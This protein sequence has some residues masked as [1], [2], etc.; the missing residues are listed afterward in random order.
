MISIPLSETDKHAETAQ[1]RPSYSEVGEEEKMIVKV[2]LNCFRVSHKIIS[3]AYAFECVTKTNLPE[4]FV[5]ASNHD[6]KRKKETKRDKKKIVT[7]ISGR[8]ARP[9]GTAA[10]FR[11]SDNKPAPAK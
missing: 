8:L 5:V 11:S 2:I 1:Y 6:Y 4:N 3:K 9:V 7:N 10:Y